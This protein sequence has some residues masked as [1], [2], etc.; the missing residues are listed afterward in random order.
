MKR[1]CRAK[2]AAW[3]KVKRRVAVWTPLEIKSAKSAAGAKLAQE[4]DNVVFASGKLSKDKY[5]ITAET[6]LTGITGIRFE[7][8]ADPRLPHLRFWPGYAEWQSSVE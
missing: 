6:E 1:R 4:A 8:L 2:Q 5:T 7:A 3:E